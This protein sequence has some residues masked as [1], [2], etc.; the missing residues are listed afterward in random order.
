MHYYLT[1]REAR[2]LLPS[3][4]RSDERLEAETL[5]ADC[6]KRRERASQLPTN[7]QLAATSTAY[8]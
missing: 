1:S 6:S 8:T 4:S 7:C 2:V 3:P 5:L